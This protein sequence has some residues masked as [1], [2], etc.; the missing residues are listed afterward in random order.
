MN[1][2][3][4]FVELSAAMPEQASGAGAL[5]GFEWLDD[6]SDEQWPAVI[7]V[8]A[9]PIACE[10]NEASGRRTSLKAVGARARVLPTPQSPH[11]RRRSGEHRSDAR[12][13]MVRPPERHTVRGEGSW[14]GI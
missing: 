3:R 5:P 9:P 8:D 13:A 1:G 11:G 10:V 12:G 7:T 2:I 6:L 14:C 4:T